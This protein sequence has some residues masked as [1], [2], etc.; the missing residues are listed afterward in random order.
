[1]K[2][3][4]GSRREALASSRCGSRAGF[5]LLEV[6][7]TLAVIGLVMS[8]VMPNIPRTLESNAD[9]RAAFHF[10]RLV[11]DLRAAA[12]R[13]EQ[14][15]VVVDSGQ[16]QDDPEIEPRQA[17]LKFD[18]DWTYRLSAPLN[19]SA[20]G[21]CDPVDADLFYEGRP[22]MRMHGAADCSFTWER[23]RS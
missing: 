1:M 13:D 2:T 18:N 20:R 22:R 11:L 10:E 6:L 14:S 19:I 15:L 3:S 8:I 16:F 9:R 7:I 4:R 23:I 12:F 17:E 5:S 21:L